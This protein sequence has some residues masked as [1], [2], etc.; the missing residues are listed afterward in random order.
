[1]APLNR[2]LGHDVHVRHLAELRMRLPLRHVRPGARLAGRVR[3]RLALDTAGGR[4]EKGEDHVQR[5]YG[6]TDDHEEQ[7][8]GD[9][10]EDVVRRP[11]L[12]GAVGELDEVLRLDAGADGREDVEAED[13][14]QLH[15]F[16]RRA[17][18]LPEDGGG[19]DG[20]GGIGECVE[21]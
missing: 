1:M 6:A 16:R 9:P 8:A 10:D 19:D 4:S 21:R 5:R 12:V 17:V 2:R 14:G 15:F 20:E 18:E 7:L 11:R 13:D 3:R